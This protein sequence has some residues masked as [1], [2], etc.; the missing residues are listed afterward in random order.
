MTNPIEPYTFS[1]LL[2]LSESA[3]SIIHFDYL[4]THCMV[5]IFKE[6][7]AR[8]FF[9]QVVEFLIAYIKTLEKR[10]LYLQIMLA[11]LQQQGKRMQ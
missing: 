2:S 9:S 3:S 5:K 10:K 4:V 6:T 1:I 7:Q 8:F 11:Q